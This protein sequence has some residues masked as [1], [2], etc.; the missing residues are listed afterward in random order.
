[1]NS[2]S[3]QAGSSQAGSRQQAEMRPISF[4]P[5]T[6]L[7]AEGSCLVSFGRT[8]VLCTASIEDSVPSFLRDLGEG[9]VTAEYSMLPRATHRRSARAKTL[10]AGR[11]MEI[12]RLIGRSLRCVTDRSLFANQQIRLDC[13]VL[14]ADGS[15]RTAS[16]SGAC[17]ALGIAFR[18]LQALGAID[19]DPLSKLVA[20]VS[21][22]LKQDGSL[23]IDPT[24]RQ[25]SRAFADA[26]FAITEDGELVEVQMSAERNPVSQE[27]LEKMLD[28]A[29]EAALGITRLQRAAIENAQE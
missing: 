22:V 27:T 4:V 19:R 18:R 11:T 24:Y 9:W 28:L 10:A 12:Q 5:D 23:Q 15:T 29:R 17:V 16:L 14:D 13:D 3:S 8:R 21:C 1:M 26:N 20:G 7:H 6:A 25:D 2:K